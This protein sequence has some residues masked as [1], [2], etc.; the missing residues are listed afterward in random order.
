MPLITCVPSP[1]AT[2]NAEALDIWVDERKELS[3][4][5]LAAPE[6]R[7]S[8]ILHHVDR[9]TNQLKMIAEAMARFCKGSRRMLSKTILATF[10]LSLL[11]VFFLDIVLR[12]HHGGSKQ[13]R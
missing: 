9:Q 3:Q 1:L 4:K 5:I 11:A 7:I 10:I 8:H 12:Q 13:H 2:K 6:L